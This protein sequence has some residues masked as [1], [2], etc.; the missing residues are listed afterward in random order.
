MSRTFSLPGNSVCFMSISISASCAE[1]ATRLSISYPSPSVVYDIADPPSVRALPSDLSEYNPDQDPEDESVRPSEEE[2][3]RQENVKCLTEL[4]RIF[5]ISLRSLNEPYADV[6]EDRKLDGYDQMA[7]L[8]SLVTC[9]PSTQHEFVY[10]DR[11]RSLPTLLMAFA[12]RC[13][14]G[15]EVPAG[16][17][18]GDSPRAILQLGS[19]N[20][21]HSSPQLAQG[22]EANLSWASCDM[23]CS[24]AS[25][26]LLSH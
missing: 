23:Q 24:K 19:S 15:R 10:S 4:A 20:K 6:A 12:H 1:L 17:F 14:S 3:K 9:A 22:Q 7:A 11:V 16:P 8:L 26:S 13:I 18:D 2:R 25:I 21:E 5:R